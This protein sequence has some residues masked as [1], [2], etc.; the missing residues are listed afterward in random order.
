VALPGPGGVWLPRKLERQVARWEREPALGLVHCG[1][2]EI[3][4]A[5]RR[6]GTCLL[7]VEGRVADRLLLFEQPVVLGGGSGVLIPRAVF[8][9][10][11]GFDPR[12]STSAD[13]DLYYRIASRWAI[14]FVPEVLL[15]Y[16]RHAGSMHTN[17]RV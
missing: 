12:L 15:Q 6:G 1:Y 7:G 8:E 16:R 2:E 3:D 13:W 11:G 9:A 14:G 10:V 17:V 5:G 4:G